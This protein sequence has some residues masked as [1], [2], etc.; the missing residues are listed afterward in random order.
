MVPDERGNPN[1]DIMR[2]GC[3]SIRDSIAVPPRPPNSQILAPHRHPP[4]PRHL[5]SEPPRAAL[6]LRLADGG[7]E[8]RLVNMQREGEGV[9]AV[10]GGDEVLTVGGRGV[11]V[12]FLWFFWG[13]GL[14]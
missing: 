7:L 8:Q 11:S 1:G 13:G 9:G 5:P 6:G 3:D 10:E 4:K 12:G 14:G 2:T